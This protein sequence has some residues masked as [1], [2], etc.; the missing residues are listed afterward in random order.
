MPQLDSNQLQH[1]EEYGYLV[2]EGVI[3]PE[4]ILDPIMQEYEGV[5]DSLAT[6]LKSDG[7]INSLHNALSFGDRVTKIYHESNA[8]HNQ[9]FDFS[10]PQK[11]INKDTPFWAGPAVFDALTNPNLL[12]VV[13]S[14]IGPEIYSNPVQ[15][16]RVKVPEDKA[17]RDSEGNVIYGATPWHQ[18]L[19]VVTEE[20]DATDLL[21]V[22]FPL[23]DT[24]IENGCLQVIPGSHCNQVLTHC[25]GAQGIQIPESLLDPDKHVQFR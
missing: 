1:L 2:V 5:L 14:V 15:H 11:G 13:E 6:R 9:Y 10:L 20:A 16:V 12:D 3:E 4:D 24:D 21:T 22:W 17:P 19:G 18:D 25:P 8:I 7:K 23:M